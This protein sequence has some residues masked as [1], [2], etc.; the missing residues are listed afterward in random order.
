MVDL[1]HTG[2]VQQCMYTLSSKMYG[3]E[4]LLFELDLE[5]L[6][7]HPELFLKKKEFSINS[8]FLIFNGT[9]IFTAG[10]VSRFTLLIATNL[11]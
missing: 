10:I 8:K 5:M 1:F 6:L 4:I 9:D 3:K 7:N 2:T 11:M